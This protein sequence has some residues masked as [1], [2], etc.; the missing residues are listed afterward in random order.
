MIG[1]CHARHRSLEYRKFLNRIDAAVPVDL[2]VHLI[3]DNY[4]THKTLLIQRWFARHPRYHL[5]LTPTN[6]S[7]LNLVE[8][9]FVEITRKQIRRGT[10][11]ST[12]AL[13]DVI[14]DLHRP[15]QRDA[16][17][18]RLDQDGRRDP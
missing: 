13:R 18:L 7:W 10:H 12:R 15:Q 9:W 1:H 11:R 8:R 4:A 5:Q 17:S 6:A 3:L 2:D 14:R 16:A